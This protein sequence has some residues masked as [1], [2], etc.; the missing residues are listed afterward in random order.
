[1]NQGIFSESFLK[2]ILETLPLA[3]FC[4]DYS[5]GRGRFIIW[6]RTATDL[7]GVE[8]SDIIGKSDFDFF[9]KDQAEFFQKKDLETLRTGKLVYIEEEPVDSVKLGRRF[10]RTWKVPLHDGGDQKSL[11]L[12]VSLDITE[13]KILQRTLEHERQLNFHSSKM[14]AIGE[15]AAGI[16]HEISNPL[17]I[18]NG[19]LH[20]M[21]RD[22]TIGAPENQ[23][24]FQ[25]IGKSEQMIERIKSIIDGL[26]KIAGEG[27]GSPL[28]SV[29]IGDIIEDTLSLCR[30]KLRIGNI[31]LSLVMPP[32]TAS[33]K[34]KCQP[35]QISQV[36][37][38]LINNSLAALTTKSEKSVTI[39]VKNN[40]ECLEIHVLDEGIG[41][42]IEN[43]DRIF[44]PYFTT[45]SVKSNMGL[46]LNICRQIIEQHGGT[47]DLVKA[48]PSAHFKI[49]LPL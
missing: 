25:M 13:H 38:N 5:S 18:L 42:A 4:K 24:L 19:L 30:E 29:K 43:E 11:L 6:N 23:M 16:A 37:L 27:P 34:I 10:V 44:E 26:R 14:V 2:E 17:A 41:I 9:P 21:K 22:S 7:W 39:E 8:A 1:V 31:E 40:I 12:G 3:V 20:Q 48:R 46:G 47:I 35:V 32:D 45:K 33:L 28:E 49:S 36:L 15:M